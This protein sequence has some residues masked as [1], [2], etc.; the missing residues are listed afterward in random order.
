MFEKKKVVDPIR[1]RVA[2]IYNPVAGFRQRGRLRSFLK[3]LRARGHDVV[4]RRTEGPGHATTIAAELDVESIDVVVA[5]GGDGT[6]N[7]VA[8]G[9]IGRPIPM[10]IAPLGTANVFAFEL[11][12]GLKLKRAAEM[13]S[14][15]RVA[16]IYPALAGERGFLLMV[17]AG[18]DARVVA[19]VNSKLKRVIGKMA[20]VLAALQE[21]A[22]NAKTT[23]TVTVDGNTH[24]AGLVIV[25][26]ASHYAGPFIIAPDTRLGDDSISVVLLTGTSRWALVRY[27]IALL[28]NRVANLSDATILT[29]RHVRLDGPVGEPIQSDGDLIGHAPMEITLGSR[30]LRILVPDLSRVLVPSPVVTPTP[31]EERAAF[32]KS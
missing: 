25:T 11:G 32:V 24:H 18:P 8:N 22:R 6:I 15:G 1:R 31:V 23:I 12:M 7:E 5:A 30:P 20:Y 28:T 17:S 2:V 4:L 16:E 21:I 26:H 9:L 3:H 10:A 29:A 19:D 14:V 27:G 13:P